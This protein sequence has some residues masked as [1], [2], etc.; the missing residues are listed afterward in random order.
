MVRLRACREWARTNRYSIVKE[1]V[2][3]GRSASRNLEKREF[4]KAML[5]DATSKDHLFDV[6]IVHKLDRFSRDPLESLT[7]KALF[8]RHNVRLISI[9]EPAVGGDSATDHLLEHI[10]VG[11]NAFYSANLGVEIRKGL[12]ERVQQHHLVFGPPFGYKA[13]I[14]EKQH[15]HK[16]TRTIS[17]A[18]LDQR[19]AP[20]VRRIF[21]LYDRGMGYK[22]I[23]VTLNNEGYRTNKGH[24]FRVMFISR[25]LRNRAYV[26][27]LLYQGRGPREPIVI[28]GFYPPIIDE[29][30]F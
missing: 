26:G 23:A 4:F 11:M 5:V 29:D 19:A 7:A 18:V 20:V 3:E 1:Y 13:E 21:E 25:T 10:L 27:T 2:D 6:V 9:L 28:P 15:S 16:R 30:I 24:L 22:S 14:V 8:K 12:E 17:R